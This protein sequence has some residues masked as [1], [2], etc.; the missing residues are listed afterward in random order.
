LRRHKCNCPWIKTQAKYFSYRLICIAPLAKTC[1]KSYHQYSS[2]ETACDD[3]AN[4][5]PREKINSWTILKMNSEHNTLQ[6]IPAF[7]DIIT[8]LETEEHP[9]WET[10]VE[11][12]EKW[13]VSLETHT[14]THSAEEIQALDRLA[15]QT[16]TPLVEQAFPKTDIKPG[17]ILPTTERIAPTTW[18][19]PTLHIPWAARFAR[20]I[21]LSCQ[22]GIHAISRLFRQIPS[23]LR[24]Q[25]E[26]TYQAD[27]FNTDLLRRC[28]DATVAF[29]QLELIN[30]RLPSFI[31]TEA[32]EQ[33]RD[34]YNRHSTLHTLQLVMDSVTPLQTFALHPWPQL[35]TLHIHIHSANP[36]PPIPA[37]AF[38]SIKRI[39]IN[40]PDGIQLHIQQFLRAEYF[41]QV[42]ELQLQAA[43]HH[44]G[45]TL[46][47]ES[48]EQLCA[49]PNL[50]TLRLYNLYMD[51]TS[52]STLIQTLPPHQ[53]KTL[54]FRS[55]K[56]GAPLDR[57]F[58]EATRRPL[59]STL[60]TLVFD[61]DVLSAEALGHFLSQSS[62]TLKHIECESIHTLDP[63]LQAIYENPI[64]QQLESLIMSYGSISQ[65]CIKAFVNQ[66]GPSALHTLSVTVEDV[67]QLNLEDCRRI[68]QKQT[69][70]ERFAHLR[71]GLAE[72]PR[73]NI[74]AHIATRT[75]W[76]GRK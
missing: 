25:D 6:N 70:S 43:N 65:H 41:A 51:E 37:N 20:C 5:Q 26:S 4:S 45:T 36:F 69:T 44:I 72:H 68:F 21:D 57:L 31:D 75:Q 16:L 3:I 76:V 67:G 38:P 28:A 29:P 18:F 15:T 8:F 64:Q 58:K 7:Q 40:V 53:L 71:R 35:Q 42:E 24:S 22:Y 60:E 11:R 12:C 61:P 9:G 46:S 13:A 30:L 1:L 66:L 10:F 32:L 52:L 54:S 55:M 47:T 19:I 63:Y 62:L 59:L 48:I 23:F 56:E 33:F 50:H 27:H 34:A 73:C 39:S 74:L 2:H 49:F 17:H 14:R